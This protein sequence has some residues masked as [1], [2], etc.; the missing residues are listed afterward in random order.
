M[1]CR[2]QNKRHRKD[3]S[4]LRNLLVLLLL[5]AFT[6]NQAQQTPLFSTYYFNKFLVNPAFTGID[7]QY[8][9]F[10]FF[11]SQWGGMPGRPITGGATAEGSFW[12]DRIGAGI[13]AINDQIGIFNQ[14]SISVLYA[15]KIKFAKHHQISIGLQ[16]SIFMNRIDFTNVLTTDYNDP[17]I[18]EQRPM[19]VVFDLNAGIS[20]R[21]K[22]LLVGFCVPQ[23]LQ[24]NAKYA[25]PSSQSDYKYVRHYNVFAQYKITLLKDNFNITPTLFMRKGAGSGFQFD[26]NLLLDYDNIVFAGAGYRIAFGV[27]AMAGVNILKRVT[28]AYSFDFTTQKAL[29]G[30]VGYTH[31]VT[32]GFHLPSDYKIKKKIKP[33]SQSEILAMALQKSND[34]LSRKLRVAKLK[35]DSLSRVLQAMIDNSKQKKNDTIQTAISKNFKVQPTD[36][37]NKTSSPSYSLDKIYFEANQSVLLDSSK[38]QLNVLVDFLKEYPKVDIIIKGYADST[39]TAEFNQALSENRAQAVVKYLSDHG[40]SPHRLSYNGFGKE[41]PIGDNTTEEGRRMNRRVEFTIVEK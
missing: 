24:P 1:N 36:E 3:F 41:Y 19:K 11:R 10:G 5:S 2:L 4:L 17:S 22:K 15:Q 25:S 39:G 9:V 16:G 20:Y 28:V 34:S 21:W 12:K 38:E 7:N 40:I 37:N 6:K 29:N 31:E 18:A 32:V 35:S 23:I 8:R 33:L 13:V 27:V 14:T 30:R 26:A